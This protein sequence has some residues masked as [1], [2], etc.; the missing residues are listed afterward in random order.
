MSRRLIQSTGV[1]LVILAKAG[2]F[3]HTMLES[4]EPGAGAELTVAPAAIVLHFGSSLESASCRI[5]VKD[6]LGNRI[7]TGPLRNDAQSQT[8]LRVSLPPLTPGR[9]RVSWLAVG[10]DGHRTNGAYVFTFKP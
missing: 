1:L 4:A 9:Y 10:R 3:G 5:M 2:A 8:S 7:V 6:A